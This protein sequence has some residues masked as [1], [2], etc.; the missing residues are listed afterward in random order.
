MPRT[1]KPTDGISD[2]PRTE[3]RAT[4]RAN[5]AP[6]GT[7]NGEANNNP[8]NGEAPN[9][10]NGASSDEVSRRAYEIYQSRGGQ[11]GYDLDHWLEAERELKPGPT[12]VTGSMPPARSKKGKKPEAGA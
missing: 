11:D 5:G 2:Q 6:N 8:T 7:A 12:S 9:G 3:R 4:K 10:A 1:N